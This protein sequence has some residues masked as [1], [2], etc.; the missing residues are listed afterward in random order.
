M[1]AERWAWATR[2]GLLWGVAAVE[3]EGVAPPTLWRLGILLK[4]GRPVGRR[5]SRGG[6]DA[7]DLPNEIL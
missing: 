4:E 6:L 2:T 5:V 7:G 3:G 1:I